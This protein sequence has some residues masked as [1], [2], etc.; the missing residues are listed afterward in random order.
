V[1][2]KDLTF[3]LRLLQSSKQSGMLFVEAPG[4]GGANSA[5]WQGQFQLENGVVKSCKVVDM[6]NGSMLFINDE[7]V[8]WLISQG[9]LEWRIAEEDIQP[10]GKMLPA[11]SI[12][13]S[14]PNLPAIQSYERTKVDRQSTDSIQASL[15]WEKRRREVFQRTLRGNSASV[16]AFPSR[17]HRQVFALVDGRRNIEEIV[18]LLHKPPD[19]ILRLMQELYMAGFIL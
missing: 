8:N 18:Q 9:R 17:D 4:A 19:V 5:P 15:L 16:N 3:L 10:P 11:S 6:R 7:A 2:T 14:N 1:Y 12:V 13:P